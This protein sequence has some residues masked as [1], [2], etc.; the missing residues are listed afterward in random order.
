M[1]THSKTYALIPARGGSKRIPDKNIKDFLGKPLI[2][3][4]IQTAQESG[5]FDEII[6][7]TDS[8]KI[9][10]IGIK[11]G[12]KVPFWRPK[13]LSDDFTP[14]LDVIAHAITTLALKDEDKLCCIYP[15]APLLQ[16]KT[17]KE[18]FSLLKSSY[19][20]CACEFDFTPFR[21]FRFE[22]QTLQMLYPEFQNTRSQ[23]LPSLYHDAGMFYLGHVKTF[24]E[25]TPIFSPHSIP[26]ILPRSQTQ[27][28]DTPQDLL[29]AEIKYKAIYEN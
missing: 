23:D 24:R 13:E 25:K 17:I 6:I 10:E 8:Q 16:A 4:S 2:A 28:I 7:S 3:Y 19:V 14:T 20:F 26:L 12:A 27:D 1:N 5:C 21:S 15:T 18:A 11:Y 9:A 29:L 22:N